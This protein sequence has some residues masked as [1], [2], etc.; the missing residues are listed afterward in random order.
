M[1]NLTFYMNLF[2]ETYI[3]SVMQSNRNCL[4]ADTFHKPQLMN[5]KF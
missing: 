3:Y 2:A 1:K 4:K 5:H